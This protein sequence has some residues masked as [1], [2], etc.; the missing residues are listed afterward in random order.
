MHYI[1]ANLFYSHYFC[2]A[3]IIIRM[4]VWLLQST[5]CVVTNARTQKFNGNYT[6]LNPEYTEY[7]RKLF[8]CGGQVHWRLCML[9]KNWNVWRT[10]KWPR[11][12]GQLLRAWVE[13]PIRRWWGCVTVSHMQHTNAPTVAPSI[14]P[15]DQ[16]DKCSLSRPAAVHSGRLGRGLLYSC[17]WEPGPGV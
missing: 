6:P 10:A 16:T 9:I 15:T 7:S 14:A 11:L 8:C 12:G 17:H 5:F 1:S 3:A 4:K 13:S 2:G